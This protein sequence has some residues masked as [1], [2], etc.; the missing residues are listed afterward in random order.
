MGLMGPLGG[1][2]CASYACCATSAWGLLDIGGWPEQ[3]KDN[4]PQ[5]KSGNRLPSSAPLN[6]T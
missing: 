6:R 1:S 5:S 2:S 3:A 4:H